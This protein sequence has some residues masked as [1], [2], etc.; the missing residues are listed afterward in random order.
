VRTRAAVLWR[1]GAEPPW[2]ERDA[3]TVE[4]LELDAP[5]PGEL[6]VRVEAAG[7]CHSDLS[8]VDGS[9][10][11]PVP[12]VLGHEAAG[13]VE[14]VGPGVVDVAQGDHVVLTFVPSCGHC[15]DCSAGRPGLCAAGVAANLEGRMLAG[16]RRLHHDGQPV[17]H[18]LGVSAFAQHAVVAR[19][20]A[21]V[22][23]PSVPLEV[24]ALLGCAVLTGLGAAVH[25]AGVRPGES[26][27]V[28]GLGGVGLSAVL[29]AGLA[30]AYPLIAVDPVEDKHA[31][32]RELGA[33]HTATPEEAHARIL[34]L[35]GGGA[36]HAIECVGHPS[37]LQAAYH[38]TAP[39]GTTVA[40][41]LPGRELNL[42]IP[43]VTLTSGG[44]TLRGSFMGSSAPQRDIPRMLRLWEAGRLPLERLHSGFLGLEGV[45]AGF[46][47]LATGRVVRQVLRPHQR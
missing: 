33:T 15:R 29:G 24:A 39:G 40:A 1:C 47:R 4:T 10:P 19:G 3:L 44:R 43:A 36:D 41:G 17:N 26:V 25:T 34:E 37:A 13:V 32:A 18:H 22:V 46:D 31:L 38:A 45:A 28:F 9:R 11:R 6:L 7:L 21:V 20:S 2:A 14:E 23:P 42:E 27:A 30:G 12:M 8:V 16:G 5:G 35:T